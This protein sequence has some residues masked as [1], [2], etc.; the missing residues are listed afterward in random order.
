MN[1]QKTNHKKKLYIFTNRTKETLG[2]KGGKKD[3][4][5]HLLPPPST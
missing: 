4:K 5:R 3:K 1:Q 2:V